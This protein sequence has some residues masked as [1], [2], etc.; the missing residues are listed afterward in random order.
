MEGERVTGMSRKTI[1]V[2][3]WSLCRPR[4][5]RRS[6]ASQRTIARV[7][8]ALS[9]RVD[10][11]QGWPRGW[12]PATFAVACVIFFFLC[13]FVVSP[14]LEP[15]PTFAGANTA[16]PGTL[17]TSAVV[18]GTLGC[19]CGVS[20]RAFFFF[21]FFF[22][23]FAPYNNPIPSAIASSSQRHKRCPP[24][25]SIG[26]ANPAMRIGRLA[27]VAATAVVLLSA[28]APVRSTHM[29]GSAI[30]GVF[31]APG[32]ASSVD[33]PRSNYMETPP[34]EVYAQDTCARQQ[35]CVGLWRHDCLI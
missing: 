2:F 23:V 33:G 24:P 25:V 32:K 16:A 3:G 1:G 15:L 35:V 4:S 28:V 30:S 29:C 34:G 14:A 5:P 12:P 31:G 7:S 21:F 10:G 11:C 6:G 19:H 13:G 20:L 22:F 17:R 8:W 26:Q 27:L 9:L 18:L